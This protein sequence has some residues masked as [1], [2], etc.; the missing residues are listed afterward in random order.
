MLLDIVIPTKN[1]K[2]KL[3]NCLNSVFH[4]VKDNL[5]NI[6]LYF[7]IQEELDYYKALFNNISNIHIE[8]LE[9]YRVPDFWN[10]HLQKTKA[11]AICYLNDDVILFTDT[12]ETIIREFGEKY[13]DYDGVMGLRQ[14]N[15][16]KDQTVEGA[17]GVIGR[18]YAERFPEK[19]VFCPDYDR[20]FSDWELWQYAK[21][22]NR[23]YF[24]SI[25]RIEHLHPLGNKALEDD[26]H[27][28]VRK[29]IK[30]DKKTFAI[31]KQ[32]NL[33]WGDSF[34]LINKE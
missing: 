5:V 3:D 2:E 4:S 18:K 15:L 1:R 20:F 10:G 32:R 31:R 6:W 33:L 28:D 27:K 29:W 14:A 26:T 24:C 25:A 34:K 22:I 19:Q 11:D 21:S 8:Y 17:F 12:I 30:G 13:P 16:P 23:F 9:F 7:S